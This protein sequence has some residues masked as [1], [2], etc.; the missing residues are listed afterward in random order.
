M[1]K[2]DVNKVSRQYNEKSPVG[3]YKTHIFL[4]ANNYF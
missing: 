3:V 1:H 4:Q 2:K